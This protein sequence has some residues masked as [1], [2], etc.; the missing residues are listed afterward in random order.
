MQ[1]VT[2][3]DKSLLVGDDAALLLLE[4]AAAVAGNDEGDTVMLNAIGSDGD[5][6]V[7]TFLLNSGSPLMAESATTTV[8][9]PDNSEAI[10]YMSEKLRLIKFPPSVVADSFDD[11]VDF[12]DPIT[13]G[14]PQD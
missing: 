10:E 12:D 13:S 7:A 14:H 6:V 11:E 2:F 8:T 1:H 3:A 5:D 9:E 4:Y